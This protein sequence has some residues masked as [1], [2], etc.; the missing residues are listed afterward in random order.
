MH[1]VLLDDEGHVWSAGVKGYAGFPFENYFQIMESQCLFSLIPNI[2]DI[3]FTQIASSDTHTLA[4]SSLGEV[5][6]WGKADYGRLGL[7]MDLENAQFNLAKK[8]V[9]PTKIPNMKNISFVSCGENHSACGTF[10]DESFLWGNTSL[11]RMGLAKSELKQLKNNNRLTK[12]L[13]AEVLRTPELLL[14]SFDEGRITLTPNK[15]KNY[16]RK[17]KTNN[18]T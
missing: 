14:I 1:T 7:E 11:G 12:D 13:K 8:I 9:A 10:N 6:V 17:A 5:Y 4:L 3:T 15:L 2:K 16:I 18:G